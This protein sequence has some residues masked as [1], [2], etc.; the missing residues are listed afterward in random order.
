MHSASKFADQIE[1]LLGSIRQ[2]NDDEAKEEEE[3][4]RA[5]GGLE[6]EIR[7]LPERLVAAAKR[8][9]LFPA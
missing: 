7:T 1:A 9:F 6:G 3:L 8:A 5:L 4:R 2:S